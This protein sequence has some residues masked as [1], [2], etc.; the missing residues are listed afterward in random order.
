MSCYIIHHTSN[1]WQALAR[2]AV[3]Y[4]KC[5]DTTAGAIARYFDE[6]DE[7]R[8]ELNLNDYNN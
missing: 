4:G 3:R 1:T 2:L 7:Y 8:K 5:D 6:H